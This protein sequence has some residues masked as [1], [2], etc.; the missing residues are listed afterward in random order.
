M[1]VLPVGAWHT[2]SCTAR[3]AVRGRLV[4]TTV[5]VVACPMVAAVGAMPVTLTKLASLGT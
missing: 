5:K 4:P 2:A 3:M 1:A